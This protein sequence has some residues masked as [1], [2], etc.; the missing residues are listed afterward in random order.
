MVVAQIGV[1]TESVIASAISDF[2]LLGTFVLWVFWEFY[3]PTFLHPSG[4]TK[5]QKWKR[6]HDREIERTQDLLESTVT[7]VLA[8]A[9]ENDGIDED[10]IRDEFNDGV[11][12][13][14]F[15]SLNRA[16]GPRAD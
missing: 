4:G 15:K 13:E 5:V 10:S 6:Q 2:G 3:C 12:P 8:L 7:A 11:R 16:A 1:V 14:D 9:E